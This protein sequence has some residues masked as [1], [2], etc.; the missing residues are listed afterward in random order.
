[1][2]LAEI[3]P[4]HYSLSPLLIEALPEPEEITSGPYAGGQ[5]FTYTIR[6]EAEWEDGTPI[7]GYDYD[8]TVKMALNPRVDVEQWRGFLTF[9]SDV[10]VDPEQPRRFT[11]TVAERYILA[12]LVTCN[13]NIYPK[14]IYDP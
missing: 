3:D 14:H 10:E 1:W 6:A 5:R 11:V 7:T 13:F 4:Y 9:I 12:D 8:F 2:P